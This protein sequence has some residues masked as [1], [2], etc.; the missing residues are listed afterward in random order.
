MLNV[1]I[2]Y[3]VSIELNFFANTTINYRFLGLPETKIINLSGGGGGA[4]KVKRFQGAKGRP[5]GGGGGPP[6]GYVADNTYNHHQ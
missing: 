4:N 2:L 3:S 1:C 5:R 6:A